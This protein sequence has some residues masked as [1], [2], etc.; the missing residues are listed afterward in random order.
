MGFKK[1]LFFLLFFNVLIFS[2]IF[3]SYQTLTK[4]IL[5]NNS[6]VFNSENNKLEIKLMEV[7]L[8]YAE[9]QFRENNKIVKLL[10]YQLG[11]NYTI[12]TDFEINILNINTTRKIVDFEITILKEDD[13]YLETKFW[14]VGRQLEF[15][16]WELTNFEN[17]NSLK[18]NY[19]TLLS[20]YENSLTKAKTNGN[21][22]EIKIYENKIKNVY[23]EIYTIPNNV[24]YVIYSGPFEGE[25][26]HSGK[27]NVKGEI[28]YVFK[29]GGAFLIKI[30]GGTKFNNLEKILQI[31]A[32]GESNGILVINGNNKKEEKKE[33]EI[34]TKQKI[35]IELDLKNKRIEE[36]KQK[37]L[38]E[39]NLKKEQKLL[40]NKDVKEIILK[41]K[42]PVKSN[43]SNIFIIIFISGAVLIIGYFGISYLRANLNKKNIEKFE[44][45]KEDRILN[46]TIIYLNSYKKIYSKQDLKKILLEHKIEEKILEKALNAV[47]PNQFE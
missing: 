47:Y 34:T 35:Q 23:N 42:V 46:E 8:N 14:C 44:I 29:E 17:R 36:E 25:K 43:N 16:L 2:N 18:K 41:E 31:G 20:S 5:L 15:K 11:R 19:E 26:L 21:S 45:S 9:F 28:D 12:L 1:I 24:N 32:C 39:E 38:K 6:M 27:T 30:D 22:T 3:S 37:K 40:E 7:N 13:L 33:E 10:N 4:E